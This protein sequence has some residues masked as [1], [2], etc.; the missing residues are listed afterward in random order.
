MSKFKFDYLK[1]GPKKRPIIPVIIKNDS[2]IIETPALIDSGADFNVFDIGIADALG[3]NLNKAKKITF[4]GV[5]NKALELKGN[6]AVVNLMIAAKGSS[7]N[8][9]APVIFTNELPNNGFALLGEVGF[10]DQFEEVSFYYKRG[11]I[12]LED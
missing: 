12:S 8:F 2:K 4:K 10:F 11:K 1:I 6:M 7:K 3:L 5:G 9:Q